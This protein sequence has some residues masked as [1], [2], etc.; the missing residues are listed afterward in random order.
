MHDFQKGEGENPQVENSE[1]KVQYIILKSLIWFKMSAVD[2]TLKML[3]SYRT[4]PIDIFSPHVKICSGN[5]HFE[6]CR[7]IKKQTS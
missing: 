1:H 3:F 6:S 4:H 5:V 2:E 7:N